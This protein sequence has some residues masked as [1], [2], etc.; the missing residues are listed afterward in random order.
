MCLCRAYFGFTLRKHFHIYSSS[1]SS[2]TA[3]DFE[4]ICEETLDSIAEK[5]ESLADT[6]L[7]PVDY[8]VQ[9]SVGFCCRY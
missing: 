8:D 5:F 3:A 2:L 4:Q 9:L 7:V 6:N 1:D